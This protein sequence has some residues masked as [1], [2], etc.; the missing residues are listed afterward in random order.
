L[1]KRVEGRGE[2]AGARR[3]ML[4]TGRVTVL[5]AGGFPSRAAAQ[6]ACSALKRS[7]YDCLV[8]DR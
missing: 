3:L 6:A 4:P 2:L 7:G 8:T 1:W 5:Q